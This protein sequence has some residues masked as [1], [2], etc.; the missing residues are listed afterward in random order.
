MYWT[1]YLVRWV[2]MHWTV[3][4]YG[5]RTYRAARLWVS[6][7][8]AHTRR[9]SWCHGESIECWTIHSSKVC[10]VMQILLMISADRSLPKCYIPWTST[11]FRSSPEWEFWTSVGRFHPGSYC[12][13][14]NRLTILIREYVFKSLVKFF[15]RKMHTKFPKYLKNLLNWFASVDINKY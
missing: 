10:N 13:L 14:W 1:K 12:F 15:T 9:D 6:H 11:R 7:K 3:T 2:V 4:T 8:N 5:H